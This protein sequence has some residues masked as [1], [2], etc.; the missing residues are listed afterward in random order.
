VFRNKLKL[1]KKIVIKVITNL[2]IS[3]NS[4]IGFGARL[5]ERRCVSPPRGKLLYELNEMCSS[6]NYLGWVTYAS[7]LASLDPPPLCLQNGT[8]KATHALL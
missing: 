8:D 6:V 2:V 7:G 1:I 5:F 4:W 3:A